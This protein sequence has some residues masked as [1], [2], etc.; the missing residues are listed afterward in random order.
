MK[1]NAHHT[2][3]IFRHTNQKL[4]GSSGA[5]QVEQHQEETEPGDAGPV[6]AH[7]QRTV[8]WLG[9]FI[10]TALFLKLLRTVTWLVRHRLIT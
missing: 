8:C 6:P 9:K 10:T 5:G 2:T 1:M 4:S 3:T 7:V